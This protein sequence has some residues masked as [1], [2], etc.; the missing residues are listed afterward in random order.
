MTTPTVVP[1]GSSIAPS[2]AGPGA[3]N[4]STA[5]ATNFT[6][7]SSGLHLNAA[8]LSRGDLSR[9]GSAIRI[10]VDSLHDRC[11]D[12]HQVAIPQSEQF[13]SRIAF[14][15]VSQHGR[16]V[17]IRWDGRPEL[18]A[19][20]VIFKRSPVRVNASKTDAVATITSN[21]SADAHQLVHVRALQPME[22]AV[23]VR[24]GHVWESAENQHGCC[25]HHSPI[26]DWTVGGRLRTVFAAPLDPPA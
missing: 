5:V 4:W 3:E 18:N 22:W 16:C 2:R 12:C 13:Y 10:T 9:A 7:S 6:A 14:I 20:E 8:T 19:A 17:A 21:F 23:L 11:R 24:C 25:R 1:F 26:I 15:P